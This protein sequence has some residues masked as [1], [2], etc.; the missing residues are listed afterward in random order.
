MA[1][2]ATAADRRRW[3]ARTL[4]QRA[5]DAAEPALGVR[6]AQGEQLAS[7]P[8][9]PA[10]CVVVRHPDGRLAQALPP[11]F[12]DPGLPD[13]PP[14]HTAAIDGIVE[15][16]LEE[17]AST[18]SRSGSILLLVLLVGLALEL[19]AALLHCRGAAR[20]RGAVRRAH[21]GGVA[22][23]HPA[24]SEFVRTMLKC[25]IY[26]AVV[27]YGLGFLAVRSR[28]PRIYAMFSRVALMGALVQPYLLAVAGQLSFV[29]LFHRMLCYAYA[30]AC[31][32]DIALAAC[33]GRWVTIFRS[34]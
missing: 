24:D 18:A 17:Y 14:E 30:K 13:T 19:A 11:G 32:G 8:F 16:A 29:I 10:P 9:A 3:V 33:A 25:E 26:Q 1:R 23:L 15:R 21:P 6:P 5:S 27:Y 4:E 28:R 31:V 20:L 22:I 34:H 7:P 2:G 12:S